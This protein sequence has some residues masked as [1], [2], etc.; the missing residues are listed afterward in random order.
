[1]PAKYLIRANDSLVNA[2]YTQMHPT[3]LI[4]KLLGTVSYVKKKRKKTGML[5]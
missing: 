4:I 5:V 2:N 3:I 1:M